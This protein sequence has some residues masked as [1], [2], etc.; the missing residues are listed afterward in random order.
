MSVPPGQDDPYPTEPFEPA[1]PAPVLEPAQVHDPARTHPASR[2]PGGRGPLVAVLVLALLVGAVGVGVGWQQRQ[3]AAEWRDRTEVRTGE[4]DEALGRAEALQRQLDEVAD[5]LSTS[6]GDVATL[7]ERITA[8][9]DEKAQAEDSATTVQVQRDAVLDLS[10][11]VASSVS[12]LEECTT[13][14]FDLQ[15]DTVGAFNRATA[16]EQ[17]DVSP[18]NGR[19]EDTTAFCNDARSAAARAAAAARALPQ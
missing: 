17:V 13:R 16:G 7:T 4:R 6:E 12:A 10:Q 1:E 14:L 11:Q 5:A 2:R 3:V 9:A 19:L 18:L 15:R 8:L